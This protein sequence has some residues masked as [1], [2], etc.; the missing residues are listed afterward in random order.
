MTLSLDD[1]VAIE[2]LCYRY[3]VAADERDGPLFVSLFTEDGCWDGPFGVRD[4][5]DAL[6]QLVRDIA[7]N[8]ALD[9]TRHWPLNI[10]IAGDSAAGTATVGLDN[11][12]VQATPDG[13]R[14]FSMSRS[15]STL[16]RRE[17]RWLFV[18]R[19]V[20]PLRAAAPPQAS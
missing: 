6:L 16:V 5:R 7:A 17:G 10:V 4:G 1:R 13:P 9:G 3:D 18:R 11:L 8:A 20:T 14:L 12:L 2:A 19:T 15:E